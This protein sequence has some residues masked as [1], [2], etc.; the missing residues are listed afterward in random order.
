MPTAPLKSNCAFEPRPNDSLPG[1][2]SFDPTAR[3]YV[4]RWAEEIPVIIGTRG[5]ALERS[6]EGSLIRIADRV[7]DVL[8]EQLQLVCSSAS[9]TA[10]LT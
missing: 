8:E 5:D 1:V 6:K 10:R 7:Q 3:A 2:M 9:L 4:R